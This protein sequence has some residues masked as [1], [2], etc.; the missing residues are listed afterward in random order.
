MLLRPSPRTRADSESLQ[1]TQH[2]D[3]CVIS[4]APC[5]SLARPTSNP[6]LIDEISASV[7]N[8]IRHRI[9]GAAQLSLIAFSASLSFA[10]YN[11]LLLSIPSFAC[12]SQD[13][14]DLRERERF[15]RL[16]RTV[17]DAWDDFTS[18]LLDT[19]TRAARDCVW[20]IL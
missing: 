14:D 4:T 15:A 3:H 6:L 20:L 7:S 2:E 9:L 8:V 19:W 13:L 18:S 5:E 10:Y 12:F 16:D 17:Q 1:T 11:I